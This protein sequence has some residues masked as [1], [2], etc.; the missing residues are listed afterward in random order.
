MLFLRNNLIPVQS[1]MEA[2]NLLRR[3]MEHYKD[4]ER[5][6]HMVFIDLE[7]THDR[8]ARRFCRDVWRPRES[9]FH[10]V[11]YLETCIMVSRQV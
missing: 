4:K 5:D 2:I 3:L 10:T 6:L 11:S 8:V 7:K 9:L 1:T